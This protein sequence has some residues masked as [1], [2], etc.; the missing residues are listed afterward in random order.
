VLLRLR[1]PFGSAFSDDAL[2][3]T[4]DL[5]DFPDGAFLQG[6]VAVGIGGSPSIEDVGAITS[7]TLV[8]EPGTLG[9]VAAA[10][11]LL[12]ARRRAPAR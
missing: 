4:L 1:G 6:L 9:L 10:L 7:L 2:P 8:P 12:A 11:A 5:A 3:E